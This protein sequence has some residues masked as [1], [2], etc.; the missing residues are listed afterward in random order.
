[1][2]DPTLTPDSFMQSK[3]SELTPDQFM[4]QKT[5]QAPEMSFGKRMVQTWEGAARGLGHTLMDIGDITHTVTGGGLVDKV[6]DKV[7]PQQGKQIEESHARLGKQLQPTNPSQQAGYGAEQFLEFFVPTGTGEVKAAATAPRWVKML[8]EAGKAAVDIGMKTFAQT[9][10]PTAA[11]KAAGIA[12]PLGAAGGLLSRATVTEG[13]QS[14]LSPKESA[15]IAEVQSRGVP[16]TLGDVT[17]NKVAKVAEQKLG[18]TPGAMGPMAAHQAEKVEAG[19]RELAKIP[20]SMPGKV[21]SEVEAG[22]G[23]ESGVRGH[24]TDLKKEADAAYDTVRTEARAAR[25]SV[26]VG[27]KDSA[28]IDPSTGQPF[29]TPVMGDVEFPVQMTPVRNSLRPYYDEL[30]GRLPQTVREASPG[31]AALKRIVEGEEGQVDALDLDKDLSTVKG[32]LRRYGAGLKDQS[33]RYSAAVVKQLEDGVQQAIGS[34][35]QG[36]L[37]ALQTGRNAVRQYHAADE[38]LSRLL[39]KN[40]SPSVIYDRLTQTS[41]RLLPDL[42]ELNR[43]APGEVETVAKTYMQ[44]LTNEIMA[45]GR[46]QRLQTGLN[47][48]RRLQ[49]EVRD[50][51]FGKAQSAKIDNFLQGLMDI[52]ADTN[53]SGT[54]KW[55]AIAEAAG[56]ATGTLTALG[57]GNVGTAAGIAAAGAVAMVAANRLA[58]LV[59][60][61]EGIKFLTQAVRLPESSWGFNK[62]LQAI[63]AMSQEPDTPAQ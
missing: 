58:K 22:M 19:S 4:Q 53:P 38:L 3:T 11:L 55:A 5:A 34:E 50:V 39:P 32:F 63:G 31:Y 24:I 43:I 28:V 14:R 20:A 62:A 7:F 45:N 33:G 17:G 23:V 26:Q 30:T 15:S 51:L 44:G 46:L 37:A 16:T 10:D 6:L 25:K 2:A 29:Q 60:S 56:I 12:A 8:V 21:A 54:G 27:T 1:M 52:G 59:T 42:K 41:G 61:P 35:S 40:A 48:L 49:P 18:F 57:G 36:A 47:N 13:V 9:K